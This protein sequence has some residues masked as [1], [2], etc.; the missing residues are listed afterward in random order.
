MQIYPLTRGF[1]NNAPP[2]CLVQISNI[3][4]HCSLLL[5]GGLL[6]VKRLTGR[7]RLVVL[8]LVLVV[9][10]GRVFTDAVAYSII[11]IDSVVLSLIN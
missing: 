9:L 3:S 11:L 10:F 2:D 1:K 8:A 6:F 4:G 5:G 7:R